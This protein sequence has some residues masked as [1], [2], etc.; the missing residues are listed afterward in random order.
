MGNMYDRFFVEVRVDCGRRESVSESDIRIA[1]E[2][3]VW[4]AYRRVYSLM[5]LRCDSVMVVAMKKKCQPR[6]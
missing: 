6:R 1:K 2:T 3:A 4:T 5:K